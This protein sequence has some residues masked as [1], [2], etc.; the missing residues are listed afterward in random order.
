MS[1]AK[2]FK[3]S[4][5]QLLWITSLRK[6]ERLEE[7][8]DNLQAIE[9]TTSYFKDIA[10]LPEIQGFHR[11]QIAALVANHWLE[12]V[13]ES[14][15]YSRRLYRLTQSARVYLDDQSSRANKNTWI[16]YIRRDWKQAELFNTPQVSRLS[17]SGEL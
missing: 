1:Q 12:I 2:M 11:R 5:M 14:T 7:L 17:V 3:M 15:R 16:A 13:P 9:V 10:V 4:A 6:D 8:E